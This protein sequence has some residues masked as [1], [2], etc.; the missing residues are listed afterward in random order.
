[1][2]QLRVLCADNVSMSPKSAAASS[3]ADL[4]TI[5]F[6]LDAASTKLKGDGYP[7]TFL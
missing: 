7:L 5:Y 6:N 4:K 3:C 2:L 1:M